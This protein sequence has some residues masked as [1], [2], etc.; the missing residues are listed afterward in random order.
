MQEDRRMN[1][2]LFQGTR[3]PQLPAADTENVA[4]GRAITLDPK[5]AIAQFAM[6]ATFPEAGTYYSSAEA[7]LLRV[8]EYSEAVG[9]DSFVAKLAAYARH[10]GKMKDVPLVLLSQLFTRSPEHAEV[11]LPTVADSPP[12]LRKVVQIMRSGVTGRKSLGTRP[13]RLLTEQLH[14]FGLPRLIRQ[15]LVG[16]NPS[17]ADVVKI[18][19]PS[20]PTDSWR[21]FYGWLL[22]REHDASLLPEQLQQLAAFKEDPANAP[23]PQ[24]IEFLQLTAMIGDAPERW[25]DLLPTM[26]WTQVFKTLATWSRRDCFDIPDFADMVID[27]L[28]NE[29]HVR[30]SRQ[31]P[32]ALFKAFKTVELVGKSNPNYYGPARAQSANDKPIPPRV[33]NAVSCC[34]DYSLA[35]APVLPGVGVLFVDVSGS[36]GAPIGSD[37]SAY[38]RDGIFLSRA[39][40]AGLFAASSL[41]ANPESTVIG[42]G[43]RA[44]VLPV[45]SADSTVTI[46]QQCSRNHSLGHGTNMSSAFGILH[47]HVRN[48]MAPAYVI[49]FSDMQTWADS[50][51]HRSSWTLP[52]E[53]WR[54]IQHLVT[55]AGH[56]KPLLICWNLAGDD[57]TTQAVGD[58]VLNI[59]GFSDALWDAAGAFLLGEE[60]TEEAAV[61]VTS[62]PDPEVWL[63]EIEALPLDREGLAEWVASLRA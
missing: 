31:F 9:D 23:I 32:H 3:G 37:M 42:F 40:V 20:P 49:V 60:A 15:G 34:V 25:A 30:N 46:A 39:E 38:S 47:S 56:P 14:S 2:R 44:A 41:K 8:L 7:Q 26:S 61:T 53:R 50:S 22:G 4:G 24:G 10:K 11:I 12:Q 21:A 5:T 18:L 33:L 63:R 28:R 16:N 58:D 19:H 59:A 17:L 57:A 62:D 48:G 45:R 36:M 13:K 35:N 54:E 43:D 55:Q 27:K 52:Q 6:T 51:S 29:A 1:K